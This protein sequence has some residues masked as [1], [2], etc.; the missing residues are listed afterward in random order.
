MTDNPWL[1][2]AD[3]KAE[4]QYK[5]LSVA[6]P[7]ALRTADAEAG[8]AAMQ[9]AADVAEWFESEDVITQ[10]GVTAAND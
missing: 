7:A 6:L 4:Q 10:W 8:R 1:R 5:A 9:S 3:A 2:V